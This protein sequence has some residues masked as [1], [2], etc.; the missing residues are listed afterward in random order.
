M[1]WYTSWKSAYLDK[2]T[3]PLAQ[4]Q[5]GQGSFLQGGGS[6]VA[7]FRLPSEAEWEAATRGKAGRL[8]PYGDQF[9]VQRSNTF[10]SHIRRTTPVGVFPGGEETPEGLM[11]MSGNV[12]E[13][14]VRPPSLDH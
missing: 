14:W 8:Y 13:W 6:R 7:V 3:P 12:W 11:D 4:G 5:G 10:E 1:D 9:D 2:S